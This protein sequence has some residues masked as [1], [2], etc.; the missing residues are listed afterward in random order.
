MRRLVD[1]LGGRIEVESTSGQGSTFHL[2][3]PMIVAAQD[4]ERP[5]TPE[6]VEIRCLVVA[7]SE[8]VALDWCRYLTHA[9]AQAEALPTWEALAPRLA[10]RTSERTVVILEGTV[11]ETQAWL[12]GLAG[13]MPPALVTVESGRRRA[14]RLLRPGCVLVDD[15]PLVL[16]TCIAAVCMA[17]GRNLCRPTDPMWDRVSTSPA[18]VPIERSSAIERG[19]LILVAEDN[20]VNQKVISR[21]LALLGFAVDLAPNGREA[22]AAWRQQPY[23][24]LLTD[25]HMPEMDGFELAR[26]LRAEETGPRRLP[27]IAMTANVLREAMDRCMAVGMNDYLTKPTSLEQLLTTLE[28]WLPDINETPIPAPVVP[29][30]ARTEAVVLDLSALIELVGEDPEMIAELLADFERTALQGVETLRAAGTGADWDMFAA[31]AERL[32]LAADAIG[33]LALSESC[34]CL[35]RVGEQRDARL[36]ETAL[37]GFESRM[38]DLRAEIA[39]HQPRASST[40]VPLDLTVLR[41]LI[42][43]DR[44]L[45]TELLTDFWQS[46]E[47][48]MARMRA[49]STAADWT[50]IGSE[51]HRLKSAARSIGALPLGM[52]AEQLERA[53]RAGEPDVILAGMETLETALNTVLAAI[54]VEEDLARP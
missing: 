28:K 16:D 44:D 33:A 46:A 13:V 39:R 50:S 9:G 4:E 41:D 20:E 51:A 23:A 53:V 30:P 14:P 1:L 37:A 47:Q 25:L 3:L 10:Q 6:L 49:A 48:G 15:A 8:R 32:R 42:G 5:S 21:Q 2:S 35:V 12:D 7:Q 45:R 19:R 40:S 36:L 17:V 31:T 43:D 26:L 38:S 52:H 34:Q 29:E 27:I 24:A 54:E 22:L 11:A 18:F